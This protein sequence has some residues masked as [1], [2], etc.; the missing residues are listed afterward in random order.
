MNPEEQETEES[1]IYCGQC[2]L[3]QDQMID[4]GAIGAAAYWCPDCDDYA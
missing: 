4:T 2:G 3:P 1:M